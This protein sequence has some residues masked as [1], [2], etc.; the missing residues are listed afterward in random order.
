M[1]KIISMFLAVVMVAAI[2]VTAI[3]TSFAA[4]ADTD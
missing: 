4:V 3:P 2:A 1:K